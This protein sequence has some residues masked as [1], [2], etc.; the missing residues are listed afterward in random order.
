LL[1][2]GAAWAADINIQSDVFK[3]PVTFQ[4]NGD[5]NVRGRVFTGFPQFMIPFEGPLVV[6]DG[7]GSIVSAV[8]DNHVFLSGAMVENQNTFPGKVKV[9][10]ANGTVIASFDENGNFFVDEQRISGANCAEPRTELSKWNTQNNIRSRDNCYNYGNNQLTYTFA[11]PGRASGAQAFDMTVTVVRNASLSDGLTWVGWNFPGNNYTCPGAGTLVYMTV[12]PG[13]DYHWYRL[14]K[15]DGKWT[16]KPGGTNATDRDASNNLITNPSVANR[17]Y[18]GLNYTDNGGYYCTC[19]SD[20]N[21][22]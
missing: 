11:Q 2:F 22:W 13:V 18:P 10:R 19:G 17:N 21:V 4:E 8:I 6:R 14:D 1:G 20:A 16:H 3:R 12:A 15:A 5:V 7:N 9:K